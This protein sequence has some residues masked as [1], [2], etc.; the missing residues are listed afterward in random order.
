MFISKKNYQKLL[1]DIEYRERYAK[2]VANYLIQEYKL[3][4][5][6]ENEL[7]ELGYHSYG[8]E[9]SKVFNKFY[10]ENIEKESEN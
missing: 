4:G 3:R 8:N 6:M 5:Q 1:S 7:K 10:T 9:Y 2:I